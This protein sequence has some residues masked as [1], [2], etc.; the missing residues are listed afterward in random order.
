MDFR[1]A[2]SNF[3]KS[4]RT[5]SNSMM[6]WM[7]G[8]VPT[9]GPVLRELLPIAYSGLEK[10]MV[11]KND[12]ERLLAIVEKRAKG[13][14]GAQ[15]NIRSYRKLKKRMKQDDALVALTEGIYGNQHTPLPIRAKGRNHM[16]PIFLGNPQNLCPP[17][18]PLL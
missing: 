10:A 13:M 14:T 12:I 17:N 7:D 6:S 2:K 1:E 3:I 5:G 11:D 15:W 9:S 16:N 4:A 18:V 8:H